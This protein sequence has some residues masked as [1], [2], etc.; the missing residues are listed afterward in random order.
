MYKLIEGS[1]GEARSFAITVGLQEGYGPTGKTH[2]PEEV[3]SLVE[4][5]L[6]AKAERGEPYLTGVVNQGVVVYAWPEGPGK[7]GSGHEP[8]IVYSGE[9]TPLYLRNLSDTEV[10]AFLDGLASHLGEK[11]GQTRVYLRYKSEVWIL[12]REDS[13][14]PT[15]EKV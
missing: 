5:Y 3:V 8:Q 12:Q 2:S 7:A 6:K 1:K 9:V 4:D 13:K 14:T 15:G 11:L 10:M